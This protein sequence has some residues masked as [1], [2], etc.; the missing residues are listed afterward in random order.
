MKSQKNTWSRRKASCLI[1]CGLLLAVIAFT[2]HTRNAEALL[3]NND[4]A[5]VSFLYNSIESPTS[6]ACPQIEVDAPAMD[7]VHSFMQDLTIRRQG[8]YG[9]RSYMD[10]PAYHLF[11]FDKS[12]MPQVE[13]YITSTGYLYCNHII[14]RIV[15]PSLTEVWSQLDGLYMLAD[16]M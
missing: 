7:K 15:T 8:F 1:I 12:G 6:G 3:L 16:S 5:G 9:D 14:Y 10:V 11:F 2:V 13:M 4:I